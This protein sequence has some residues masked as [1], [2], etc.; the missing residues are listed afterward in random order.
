VPFEDTEE[1]F[2]VRFHPETG[3]VDTLEAIKIP[4]DLF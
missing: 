1:S 4:I 3:R 2:V